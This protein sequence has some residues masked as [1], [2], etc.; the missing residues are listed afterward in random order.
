MGH[1]VK[2]KRGISRLVMLLPPNTN[3]LEREISRKLKRPNKLS[4]TPSPD[5]AGYQK[6]KLVIF[7]CWPICHGV[8]H[9][10]GTLWKQR[11]F[12]MSTG[13]SIKNEQVYDLTALLSS[14]V[15]ALKY[16]HALK[17]PNLIIRE[18]PQLTFM[19]R[20]QQE[21]L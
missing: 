13:T 3:Y 17:G 15:A 19:Q 20:Q 11:G 14:E 1:T 2:M 8:A 4:S 16:R 12:L 6:G 7:I 18:M 9:E 5:C 21:N 10:F